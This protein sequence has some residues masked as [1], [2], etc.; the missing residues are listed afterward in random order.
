MLE[1]NNPASKTMRDAN[2]LAIYY[3]TE[4]VIQIREGVPQPITSNARYAAGGT[5]L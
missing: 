5:A 1:N 3:A 2:I 4:T